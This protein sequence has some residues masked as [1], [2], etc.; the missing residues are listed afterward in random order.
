MPFDR[1]FFTFTFIVSL[2]FGGGTS[3]AQVVLTEIMFNP[4]G[5]ENADEFIEIYNT[6][7]VAINLSRWMISDG[8]SED[9]LRPLEQGLFL[10]PGQ[11][12]LILD[13]GYFTYESDTYDGMIP[14]SA[15]VL[16]I[17]NNTFGDRGLSNSVA[18]TVSLINASGHTVSQ[19]TY[20]LDN[21]EGYS[22]E[23]IVPW[24]GDTTTN[25]A[26]ARRLKGSPGAWNTVS[27]P[28]HDLSL[29]EFWS[30]PEEPP[31][32]SS[33]QLF[34]KIR[35][36]GLRPMPSTALSFYFDEDI[37]GTFEAAEKFEQRAINAL[38]PGDSSVEMVVVPIAE[39]GPRAFLAE[40]EVDD[41]DSSNDSRLLQQNISPEQIGLVINEIQYRPLAGR[42]EW[43]EFYH[44]SL[45]PLNIGGWQFSD[46]LGL[47]DTSKR[48][49]F[50]GLRLDAG[51]FLILAA[52][53]AIFLESLSKTVAVVVWGEGS[54]ALNNTGESLVLWDANGQRIDQ[55]NYDPDWGRDED[56]ISL[57][58]ISPASASNE[59]MNWASS[60]DPAGSTP[61]RRN[62][63]FYAPASASASILTIEPNPFSPDGDGFEDIAFLRYH[64][65]YS[66]SR[67]D[68][69]I[70]D[71]RGRKVRWLANN[72]LVG[73]TG[74]KLWDGRDDQGRELPVGIYVVYLEALAQGDT[75]IEKAK[76]AVAIARR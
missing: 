65:R 4:Y 42:S 71:V 15:L 43:V 60:V 1:I 20:T 23:K 70:F 12:G 35:N 17:S 49:T 47:T 29:A 11:F 37:S 41:D 21:E 46:A 7:S 59:P 22:D 53:S 74:E 26:N 10:A 62:S 31:I 66:N 52:D 34:A 73:Q 48:F 36:D 16:T 8:T 9:S 27:P 54:P 19:Y 40:L 14:G 38:S 58:R 63:Q 2:L 18:E 55:V 32:G 24:G 30:E 68:L 3:P 51:A 50:T 39:E 61:G 5:N 69:K 56:G 76:R 75:R 13:P 6:D 57:E 45:Y 25:W 64:L 44:T 33:F 67:L 72:E 28:L